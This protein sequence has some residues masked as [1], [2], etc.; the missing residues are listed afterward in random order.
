MQLGKAFQ[1]QSSATNEQLLGLR[2][3]NES[4]LKDQ[5][6]FGLR[7]NLFRSSKGLTVLKIVVF[8]I[9]KDLYKNLTLETQFNCPNNS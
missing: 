2:M 6:R 5:Q 8:H 9:F 3:D 7:M 1:T 4:W